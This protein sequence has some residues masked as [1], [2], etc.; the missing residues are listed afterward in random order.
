M[1]GLTA[2]QPLVHEMNVRKGDKILIHAA[3]GVGHF[4][5]QIAKN[6]GAEVIATSSGKNRDF[7]ML[8]G[9]DKHIDYHT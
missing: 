6:L 9:A 8:L 1:A 3:S 4:T 2:W 5:V 7:V